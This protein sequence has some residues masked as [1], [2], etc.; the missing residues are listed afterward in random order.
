MDELDLNNN[1]VTRLT[2]DKADETVTVEVPGTSLEY[3][4]FM[5][6]VELLIKNAGY[7]STE[8]NSYITDWAADI[9]A[10]KEN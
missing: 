3:T 1:N 8:I 6:L 10:T 5:E 2:L 9:R 4:E 7:S